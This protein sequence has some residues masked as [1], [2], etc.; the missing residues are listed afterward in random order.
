MFVAARPHPSFG[1]GPLFI[2]AEVTPTLGD[3]GIEI[4]WSLAVPAT[5]TAADLEQPLFLLWPGAVVGDPGLGPP[6]P[7]LARY[8]EERGFTAVEDGRLALGARNLYQL[9]GDG[10]LEPVGGGAPFVT[11]VRSAG[12]LGLTP[13]ATWIRIPWSPRMVN[14]AW[15]TSLRFR[16]R[17]LVKPKP[18]TWVEHTFW[19]ERY[20]L[21]LSFNDVRAR[22]VFPMYSEHRD[23]LVRLAEAPAQLI[24]NFAEADRLKIDELFPQSAKRQRSESLESTD[25]VSLYLDRSEGVVPQTLTVQ[26]G[27]FSGLQSWAPVLIPILFFVLGNL[28]GP[29]IQ[30]VLGR[31]SRSIRARVEVGRPR[32][33]RPGRES[34]V[35]LPRETVGRI[36]PGET[37]RAEVLRLCGSGGEEFEQ[38]A[39]PERRTLIYRGKRVVPQRRWSFG[40]LATV[41]H[42]DVEHH[43]VEIELER[44]VVCDVQ[45]R[46]RRTRL[47]EP[48]RA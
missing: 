46:V 3:V 7:A 38:L 21:S 19:G 34:G 27:Y 47:S 44:E 25:T 41:A 12:A 18:G 16:A 48:E 4:L 2:Q 14:L 6:D 9:E 1:V 36:R 32:D 33:D 20:R 30:A 42:W 10:R 43:E 8:V 22:A 28:A 26:F 40:W 39:A 45:A 23:R 5:R 24:V 37:T 29:L 31:L 13:P 11:F 35:V 17:G 15:I